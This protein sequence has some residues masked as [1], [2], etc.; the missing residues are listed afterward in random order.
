MLFSSLLAH[1]FYCM[2][3]HKN[4]RYILLTKLNLHLLRSL[5]RKD[6]KVITKCTL[7][8][9]FFV[10]CYL[11]R[12]SKYWTI[13][14]APWHADVKLIRTHF[15]PCLHYYYYYYYYHH[16]LC[17]ICNWPS[18]CWRST[19]IIKNWIELNWITSL[20]TSERTERKGEFISFSQYSMF[21]N[22]TNFS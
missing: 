1:V 11:S 13:S 4:T 2:Y 22:W 21:Y 15:H 10:N 18:G 14:G 3:T 6:D 16:L 20:C 5:A 19:L 17:C 12:I 8:C 7:M 9:L